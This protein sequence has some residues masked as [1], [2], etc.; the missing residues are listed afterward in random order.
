MTRFFRDWMLVIGM[1]VGAGAYLLYH[2]MDFLHP[3]GPV[4]LKICS[5]LQPVL[6]F[7]MLFLSFTRIEPQQ[8][9]P[10][11]W[12]FWL[13][14]VQCISFFGLA[15]LLYFTDPGMWKI[16]VEAAMLALICPT[17]TAAA[18][19]TGKL[20]GNMAGVVTYTVLINLLTAVAVPL[21]LPILHPVEGM[22]FSLAFNHILARVFPLLIMPCITAWLVRYLLP[23]FHAWLLKFPNLAFYLWAV[24]LTFAILMCTRA[25]VHSSAPVG[26]L[27]A[28]ALA[29]L[30]VCA[31]NFFI[32]RRIGKGS[33]CP[34]SAGQAIGQKNTV[35][36][37][38]MGYT[39]LDPVTSVVGGF[40]SIWQN[41]FNS[42][43][44]HRRNRELAK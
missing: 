13:L 31:F 18:V 9:K 5:T 17:A 1:A 19:V 34:I 16:P 3:A 26:L 12:Q 11:R 30:V 39:F 38:W 36:L 35:L 21:V 28:I 42:W 27:S 32:G 33:A 29:G 10:H 23:K 37:I 40:Y 25:M 7:L 24:S 43:Q 20:G 6:L 2:A 4:L 44:L 15:A 8:L 41:I 22:T 14:F